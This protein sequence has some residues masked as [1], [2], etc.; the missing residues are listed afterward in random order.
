MSDVSD[1][2][3]AAAEVVDQQEVTD[4]HLG[5]QEFREV[6]MSIQAQI[7][8]L[9]GKID[10][11]D[12]AAMDGLINELAITSYIAGVTIGKLTTPDDEDAHGILVG[13]HP[14][15]LE[16]LGVRALRDGALSFTLIATDG[17]DEPA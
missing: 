10:S 2:F 9:M 7:K 4:E 12:E 6:V 14:E 16:Q 1:A 3:E 13:V 8:R 5:H 17:S 15:T 11:A